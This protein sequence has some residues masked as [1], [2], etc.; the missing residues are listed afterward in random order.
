MDCF[1]GSILF[2]LKQTF[3]LDM[4][5]PSQHTMLL[6]KLLYMDLQNDLAIIMV[7]HTILLLIK[8]FTLQQ[9]K[10]S[11]GPVTMEFTDLTMFP[12]TLN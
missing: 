9:M 4:D 5:F 10:Y 3:T 2:L 1:Q 7:F 6:P 12:T 8:E 11:N